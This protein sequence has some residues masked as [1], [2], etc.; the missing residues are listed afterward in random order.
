MKKWFNS[1]PAPRRLPSPWVFPTWLPSRFGDS[2]FGRSHRPFLRSVAGDCV[3]CSSFLDVEGEHESWLPPRHHPDK[4]PLRWRCLDLPP[5]APL[6][7]RLHNCL[8]MNPKG[9]SFHISVSGRM[10]WLLDHVV[11]DSWVYPH[12]LLNLTS[13]KVIN[14]FCA[15]KFNQRRTYL[16]IL[17]VTIYNII[18]IR[19]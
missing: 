18:K 15:E 1:F 11:L 16:K 17:G 12:V 6:P 7:R 13:C 19:T 8:G 14:I 9:L 4:D 3:S 2:C 5:R 10:H